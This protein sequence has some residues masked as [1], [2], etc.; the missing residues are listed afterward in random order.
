MIKE[1]PKHVTNIQ[2]LTRH[3]GVAA[4]TWRTWRKKSLRVKL[5][6]EA[7]Y[8]PTVQTALGEACAEAEARG[9]L[10]KAANEVQTLTADG[11]QRLRLLAAAQPSMKYIARELGIELT[12]LNKWVKKHP[13]IAAALEAGRGDVIK[14]IATAQI[15]KA[16]EGDT[17]AAEFVA[18]AFDPEILQKGNESTIKHEYTFNLP[19]IAKPQAPD[20]K[21][22]DLT[23]E[24]ITDVE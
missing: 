21:V 19:Q 11:L 9:W 14:Q 1:R 5:A 6:V 13:P 22:I 8:A 15:T 20:E 18:K 17:R 16:M 12:T 3:T 10:P 24:D 2:E 4:S 7:I 23:A